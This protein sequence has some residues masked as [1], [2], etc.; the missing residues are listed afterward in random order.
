MKFLFGF[1]ALVCTSCSPTVF[2]VDEAGQPIEDARVIP[3]SRGFDWP[4]KM[5][6]EKGGVFVHQ[7]VPAIDSVRVSKEG[8][9]SHPLVNFNLPKPVTVVLER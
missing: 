2:V 4:A 5:T 3:M 7:D 8:Y 1:L 6:N 9:R